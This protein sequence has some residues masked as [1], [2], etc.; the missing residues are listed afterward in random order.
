MC[1][2]EIKIAYIKKHVYKDRKETTHA[3]I[4]EEDIH[5]HIYIKDKHK[6]CKKKMVARPV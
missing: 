3:E 4:G 2:I 6:V 5:H 1:E